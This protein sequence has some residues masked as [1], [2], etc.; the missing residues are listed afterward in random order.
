MDF[1]LKREYEN[2]WIKGQERILEEGFVIDRSLLP[3]E[4]DQRRSLGLY[5]WN[6]KVKERLQPVLQELAQNFPQ[7]LIIYGLPNSPAQLH[8]SIFVG[9]TA[10]IGYD[11]KYQPLEL[12]YVQV[13]D[14]VL[15]N[16]SPIK[17]S[18]QGIVGNNDAIVVKGYPDNNYFNS[19]RQQLK[20]QLVAAKLDP[21]LIKET[22]IFHSTIARYLK[23]V[24]DHQ[25]L[26]DFIDKYN[27]TD[28]GEDTYDQ[29]HL[30]RSSWLMAKE[31]ITLL[32]SY[33]LK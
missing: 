6:P 10:D 27:Q 21:F 16:A 11:T 15:K 20:A 19:L 12:Q 24:K 4:K 14:T 32:K 2:Y 3:L 8:V 5:F 33:Q 13:F 25:K 22:K 29:M 31:Q 9:M 7:E 30:I 26:I 18:W 1:D 17:A 28:F 23:P